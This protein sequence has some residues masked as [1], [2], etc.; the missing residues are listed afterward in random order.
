MYT[1]QIEICKY[2]Y[3]FVYKRI[4]QKQIAVLQQ[5]TNSKHWN[6]Q[7]PTT[8]QIYFSQNTKRN[9]FTT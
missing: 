9:K 2:L 7:I 1:L 4:H 5:P 3:I 6:V 8:I